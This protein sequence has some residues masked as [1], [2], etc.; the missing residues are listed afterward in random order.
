MKF[1]IPFVSGCIAFT[2]WVSAQISLELTLDQDQFLPGESLMVG[3]RITNFS[4]RTLHLG[5]DSDW[6]RISMEGRDNYVVPTTTELP[7]KGEFEVASSKVVTRRLDVAPCFALVRPGRYTVSAAV[8]LKDWDKELLCKP[9]SFDI[10]AGTT[11]WE[12]DVGVS[13]PAASNRPPEVRKYALLQAIHLKQMKLYVRVT[14]QSGSRVLRVFPIGPLIS[15]SSP[16]HQIDKSSNLY[17]LYQTGAKSFNFSVINPDGSLLIRQTYEYTDTRPTLK[18]DKEGRIYVSGGNRR[19][20]SDDIP[21]PLDASNN[22]AISPK[23]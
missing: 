7:V 13:A 14:D 19:I 16:E 3:V 23:P 4:G 22:D 15:F 10:I 5:Q 6:L 2:P 11:L 8:R 18:M 17:V 12:Q 9:K 20:S 21:L 1:W